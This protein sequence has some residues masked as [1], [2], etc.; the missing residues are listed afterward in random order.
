MKKITAILFFCWATQLSFAQNNVYTLTDLSL[1]DLSAFRTPSKNWQVVANAKG[2]F[3]DTNLQ[4]VAGTGV[5]ANLYTQEFQYKPEAN[6]F[7]ALEHGDMYLE[8][9]FMLPKGSNSGIYF[10]SRYEVQLYDSWNVKKLEVKDCGSI[11]ERWDEKRPEGKKGYE[12]RTARVNAS[13]APATWQHLEVLFQAPKFDANGKKIAPAKFVKVVLNGVIIHENTIV[14]GATRSAAADDE[15]PLAPLMIQGD[16]GQVFFKNIKYA[17][18]GD[19]DLKIKDMT[20]EYY[21]TTEANFD[22]YTPKELVRQGKAEGFDYRL[23]DLQDKFSLKFSG[24]MEVPVEAEYTFTLMLTGNSRLKI[25]G[26][27]WIDPKKSWTWFYGTP[28]TAT[29]KLSAGTH[30]FT[31]QFFKQASWAPTALAIFVQKPNSKPLALHLAGSMPE[32]PQTGL[33]ELK[34]QS[35]PE[36][37]RSFLQFGNQKKTHCL[38]VGDP[39]EVN[40]SYDLNQ[41]AILQVWKGKFLNMNEMWFERGEPQIALPL[42]A[43]LPILAK[44]PVAFL[45]DLSSNLPDSSDTKSLIYKG[46]TLSGKQYPTFKFSLEGIGFTDNLMPYENGKGLSR[47]LKLTGSPANK[48]VIFRLADG[49]SIQEISRNVYAINNQQYFLQVPD[50]QNIKL[51]IKLQN[52]QQILVAEG[53]GTEIR[54]DIVW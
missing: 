14:T 46:Y 28:I 53:Q 45:S 42:G 47:T 11:Y 44:T 2:S 17:I 18:L 49:T 5:L 3:N 4:T 54:Y 15:K 51:S 37:S 39:A 30:D 13:F 33:I 29:Q 41:A 9:D 32:K 36:I 20:Y 27:D 26:K 43:N 1:N 21:E 8:M 52:G 19:L 48:K 34:T 10:Q 12:G 24:K 22:K 35:E 23:A 16:H 31:F 40:Y 6:L 25:D 38:S 7:S 50:N